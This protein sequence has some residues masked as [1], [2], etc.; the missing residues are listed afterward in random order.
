[1]EVTMDNVHQGADRPSYVGTT[2]SFG[3]VDE[4]LLVSHG[5]E[6]VHDGDW[7]LML[8][9]VAVADYRVILVSTEGG[10]PSE[11]QRAALRATLQEAER[12][13]PR[14]AV[15]SASQRMRWLNA[16]RDLFGELD[17]KTFGFDALPE[18]ARFLECTPR[19]ERL[20]VARRRAHYLIAKEA[21]RRAG[22][23]HHAAVA[24]ANLAG[25]ELA[26]T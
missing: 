14:I 17:S 22:L 12:H 8:A 6:H 16:A 26:R 20:D 11:A 15:L 24:H 1:M 18:A 25:G 7:E 5:A 10:G 3:D 9:R 21:A 13:P 23:R 2:L 4:V 19:A